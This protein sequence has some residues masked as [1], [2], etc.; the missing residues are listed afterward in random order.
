MKEP[1]DVVILSQFSYWIVLSYILVVIFLTFIVVI[2]KILSLKIKTYP[3]FILAF[4]F[5]LSIVF[6]CYGCGYWGND[7]SNVIDFNQYPYLRI[8]TF[9][10]SF[11]Y[12]MLSPSFSNK[13]KWRV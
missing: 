5:N 12:L 9:M 1:Y 7:F 13:L 6:F 4:I 11:F 8:I 2:V 10:L 3:V